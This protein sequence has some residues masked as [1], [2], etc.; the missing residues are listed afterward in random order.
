M[1]QIVGS[2]DKLGY[3]YCADCRPV[4]DVRVWNAA[5][6]HTPTERGD[7]IYADSYPHNQDEC[8]L[9]HKLLT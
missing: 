6:Q 5:G 3:I 1:S 7:V 4:D 2:S 8:E 9:C